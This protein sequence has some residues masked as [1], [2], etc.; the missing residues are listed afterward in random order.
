M[1]TTTNAPSPTPTEIAAAR[2]Q[3]HE[4][5]AHYDYDTGYL[6]NLL[7]RSPAAHATFTAAMGMSHH[8]AALPVDVHMVARIATLRADDCGACTQLNLRMAVESGVDRELLRTVL[9]RPQALP[10]VHRLAYEHAQAVVRGE[11]GD[12]EVVRALEKAL[13]SAAFA[14]LCVAIVGSRIF[15]ALKRALGQ[16]HA[17]RVPSLDF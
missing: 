17:C 8:R 4:F 1:T 5:A 13:G 16:E 9:E 15:P 10:P 12:P 11:N 3:L 7:D 2:T 6:E 14:E